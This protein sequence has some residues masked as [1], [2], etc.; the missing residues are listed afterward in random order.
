MKIFAVVL[1]STLVTALMSVTFIMSNQAFA[2]EYYVATTGSDNNHGSFAKPLRNIQTAADKMRAGDTTFIR[3]GNY[4][5]QVSLKD[6]NGTKDK[7]FTFAA[8]NNE[9]VTLDGT[10]AIKNQWKKYRGNIYQTTIKQPIWQLFVNDKSMTSARW[11]NGNW[12]DGSVWDKTKSMMWPAKGKGELGTYFN[13]ELSALDFDLTGGIVV[14]NSGSFKT[15]QTKITAHQAGDD[16]FSYDTKGVKS[17]FS[18]K[19]SGVSRHGYFLEGKLGLLDE[20]NEWFYDVASKKLYL[21]AEQGVNPENLAI[22]GKVQSY[23]FNISHSSHI[24]LQGINFFATTFNITRSSFIKVEDSKLLYPSYS[25]RMLGDTSP[26]EVTKMLVKKEHS[27]AKNQ[28]KNCQIAYTDG[29]AIEMNGT[30]NRVENCYMHNI[31]YSCTHKGGYT[32]NMVNAKELVFSRNTIHTTGC[33][34]LF[35]AGVRN[36]VELNDFSDSGH[37]QNDGSM[38][39][40]S[41]KQ[42][43]DGIVRYNWVHNS[44]KQGIRFDNKNTPNAPYGK[45]GNVFNNVAWNTDRIFFKG[46]SHFIF[47]NLSF[48]NHQND[49]IISSNTVIQGHNHKTITRNNIS[50]KFSGNRTKPR[51]DYPIPG[52]VDHNFDGVSLGLD[53][54]SQLRDVDNL[55]FRP[56]ADSML[57]DAGAIIKGK[58]NYYLGKAPDIGPYEFGALDYWIPGYQAEKASKPVPPLA[59]ITVKQDADLMWLNAYKALSHE[60]YFGQQQS[61]VEGANK[62]SPQYQGVFTHN[63]FTPKALQLGKTYYWR[64]DAMRAGKL[65]KGDVWHFTVE[66]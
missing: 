52:I 26:I 13:D 59:S 5:E 22:S 23:A 29:P 39:Q 19:K 42:Q 32:L 46:E 47:N 6:V 64:V 51:A 9:K 50:N 24:N 10:I 25:K 1:S 3:G 65:I 55:D 54:R 36:R 63:I 12:Y 48:D 16:H 44:V 57:V 2:T 27:L 20:E 43:P 14:V 8:F 18:F 61:A 49:L 21:W 66:N 60:V 28:L 62:K 4:L 33:S 38:I 34:E 35:K 17:H 15:Y 30:G 11:P 7:P 37:L 41:V 31:D 45:N 58:T 56:K 40:L 53:V